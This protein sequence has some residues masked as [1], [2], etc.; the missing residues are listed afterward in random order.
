VKGKRVF[1]W[2]LIVII[3]LVGCS[4]KTPPPKE[5]KG[6][7]AADGRYHITNLKQLTFKGDNGEAYWSPDG[8]Q[9]IFQS[10][11]DGFDCDQIYIMNADGSNKRMVSPGKGA[12]TCSYFSADM[13]RIIF[14][15]TYGVV[16]SCPPRPKPKPGKYIWPV[17]PY[18]IYSAKPDG[19]DLIRIRENPGYDA[20]PTVCFKTGKVIFTSQVDNDLELFT[21]NIDGSDVKRLTYRLGYDGGPY[22]SPD[23]SKIVWRAW[24]PETHEDSV[25][26]IENMKHNII[27]A[28]PLD[29]YVMNADGTGVKRLTNNGATN[30]APSWFPDGKRI[31]FSSNMDDWHEELHAYGHNF[32]LY[33]INIDGTG[34]TRL[35]YNDTF[36]SFPMFSPDGKK[37]LFASNRNAN[38]PMATDIYLADWVE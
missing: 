29:I 38:N 27:E 25:R 34:L 8:K 22:F 17:F 16:D 23:G 14:A 19:S 7:N 9:I 24:Y 12:C 31:I 10:K 20:E 36:D 32:E 1:W 4:K 2:A 35:T 18:D 6:S 33:M 30:W 28:V 5:S 21:M 37:L 13:S 3:A 15:S 26:W 11:R